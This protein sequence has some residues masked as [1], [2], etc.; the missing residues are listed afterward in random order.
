MPRFQMNIIHCTTNQ[1]DLKESEK[2]ITHILQHQVDED[3]RIYDKNLKN[4]F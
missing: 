1:E 2:K 4:L 3:V